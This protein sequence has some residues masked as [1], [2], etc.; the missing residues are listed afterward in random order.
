MFGWHYVV[1]L[2]SLSFRS[3]TR[4]TLCYWS[5][6]PA[7]S[8]LRLKLRSL[9]VPRIA[10]M[11][12][13]ILTVL[14]KSPQITSRQY[15]SI[16][17]RLPDYL[18][19]RHRRDIYRVIHTLGLEFRTSTLFLFLSFIPDWDLVLDGLIKS[20]LP[21][22]L[23][24]LF[25]KVVSKFIHRIIVIL[26]VS[27]DVVYGRACERHFNFV[28]PSNLRSSRRLPQSSPIPLRLRKT[29]LNSPFSSHTPSLHASPLASALSALQ[30][31]L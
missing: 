4:L 5:C 13:E 1:D 31:L 26:R 11:A 7:S 16:A 14:L 29:L 22:L 23:S 19:R 6:W 2:H 18:A 30:S 27:L 20:F 8:C 10:R 28:T 12:V 15:D 9:S 3:C 24:F 25:L 21:S 17:S